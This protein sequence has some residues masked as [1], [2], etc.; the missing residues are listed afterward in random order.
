MTRNKRAAAPRREPDPD[1]IRGVCPRCGEALVSNTYYVSG[2]GY[3]VVWEC[4]GS[5]REQPTCDYRR[6][7]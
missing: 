6:P 5:H 7:L 3:L 4:W 2:R 1:W